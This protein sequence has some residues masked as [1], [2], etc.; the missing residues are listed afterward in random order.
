[1]ELR[2]LRYFVAVAE[3][4]SLSA[5]ARRL[6]VVQPAL[7]RQLRA[8]EE[9]LGVALLTRSRRRVNSVALTAAGH[10][11][12][13][14][15]RR[16]LG[17]AERATEA[18]R[19]A[20]GDQALRGTLTLGHPGAPT[21]AFLQDALARLGR[22][23]PRITLRPHIVTTLRALEML[24]A[25]ELDAALL[26]LSPPVRKAPLALEPVGA[27][28]LLAVFPADH[29]LARPADR[30]V[31][32]GELATEA[33]VFCP[34]ASRE[35]FYDF[36]FER[37]ARAGFRPRVV[38]E[39]VDL[40]TI[41]HLV[42]AGAGVSLL[43][44][45]CRQAHDTPAGV[46]YRSLRAPAPLLRQVLAWRRDDPPPLVAQLVEAVRAARSC[47]APIGRADSPPSG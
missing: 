32:L 9:A 30:P 33:F 10:V 7:S 35:T 42:A 28:P 31:T 5:A 20:G 14:E 3:A 17:Q 8:L 6:H 21:L 41:P 37:C 40:P 22:D 4:G 43:P 46:V 24:G 12:L 36:V 18:T 16:T 19:A 1:M 47:Q 44:S 2:H 26:H 11:Y 29:P 38:A 45:L 25:G 23:H 34:R 13:E 15:A 39:S 27:D